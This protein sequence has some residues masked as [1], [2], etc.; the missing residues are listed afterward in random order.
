METLLRYW[1][2]ENGQLFGIETMEFNPNKQR[3]KPRI[4]HLCEKSSHNLGSNIQIAQKSVF[5][6]F[7]SVSYPRS[8]ENRI[9]PEV[10]KLIASIS[11]I[12]IEK[13]SE[14]SKIQVII[15]PIFIFSFHK[16][17]LSIHDIYHLECELS[18]ISMHLSAITWNCC[19]NYGFNPSIFNQYVKM[20]S[21]HP[22][23]EGMLNM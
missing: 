20:G 1:R 6:S 9:K 22:I 21:I 7:I 11:I 17:V 2:I 23:H 14:N 16:N 19:F 3:N 18:N 13:V 8:G 10:K 12:P 15:R 4:N 5:F